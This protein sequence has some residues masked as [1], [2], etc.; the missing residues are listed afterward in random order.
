MKR[1]TVSLILM[2]LL[3]IVAATEA[4]AQSLEQKLYA[5]AKEERELIF[6]TARIEEVGGK[7]GL[8]KFSKRY[9][10]IKIT[11]TA[12]AGTQLPAR[13]ISEGRAG[14]VTIDAYRSGP[15]HSKV[16]AE[17]DLLMAINPKDLTGHPVRTLHNNR[18]FSISDHITNFGYNTKLVTK[19]EAPKGYGDMLDPKWKGKIV[20]DARGGQIAHLLSLWGDEKFWNFVKA[21]PGQKPLW[22]IRSTDSMTKLAS[23][24][25]YVGNASYVATQEL[26]KKGAPIE[27][28]FLSP[29]RTLTRGVSILKGAPHPNAARLF[30][31]WLFSSEGLESLDKLGVGIAVKGTV[32]YEAVT[33][34]QA[35]LEFDETVEELMEREKVSDKIAEIW[36]A[37]K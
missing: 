34:A 1:R 12:V 32:L 33:A 6:N 9:P 31:T 29:A 26:K 27:F 24:E 22:A 4:I 7:E 23:G 19:A 30:L 11:F 2:V 36:G 28:S 14:R 5:A 25:A 13:L 15:E 18:F 16:L 17:R 10:G 20:L 3:A 21:M 8:E 35:K 37:L